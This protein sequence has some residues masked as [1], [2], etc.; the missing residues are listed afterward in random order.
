MVRMGPGTPDKGSNRPW[1]T[2]FKA[3]LS[4]VWRGFFVSVV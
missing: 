4:D 1:D 2:R 3:P